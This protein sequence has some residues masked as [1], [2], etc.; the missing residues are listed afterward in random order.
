MKILVL[1]D[2]VM[3]ADFIEAELMELGHE[4]VGL[5][6]TVEEA[7]TLFRASRPDVAMVDMKLGGS[8]LGTDLANNLAASGD[9]DGT[10]ILYVTGQP[11]RVHRDARFGHA[12]L[13]KPYRM[14]ALEQA[15]GIV[16]DL[17]R[18]GTTKAAL[19]HGLEL[20]S[21]GAVA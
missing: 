19:P 10:G 8:A 7:A 1:E 2:D 20:L 21:L 17:S 6:C 14:A 13:T 3:L 9:L 18:L 5:A 11:E 15:L 12:V 4:V 16:R